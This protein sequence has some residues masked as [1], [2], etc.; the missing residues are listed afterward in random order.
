MYSQGL[1]LL[2]AFATV[3]QK[4]KVIDPNLGFL[5]QLKWFE[6]FRAHPHLLSILAS[7]DPATSLLLKDETSTEATL[8]G[9]ID[10]QIITTAQTAK[11]LSRYKS[12]KRKKQQEER[13]KALL[14]VWQGG[15]LSLF[16][17]LSLSLSLSLSLCLSSLILIKFPPVDPEQVTPYVEDPAWMMLQ[18][19]GEEVYRCTSCD[20]LLCRVCDEISH[21]TQWSSRRKGTE[22]EVATRKKLKCGMMWIEP[23]GWFPPLQAERGE[24]CCPDCEVEV[25]HWNWRGEECGCGCW[26]S[27]IFALDRGHIKKELFQR[28]R[29]TSYPSRQ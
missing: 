28:T 6:A 2:T 12:F 13:M 20:R 4:R 5:E 18:D 10:L 11:I 27:P 19:G 3:K 1:S 24:L 21:R 16:L 15:I 22:G 25:G 29:K 17:F 8:E 9:E 14:A 23:V 26:C 7:E